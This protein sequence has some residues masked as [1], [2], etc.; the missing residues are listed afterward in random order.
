MNEKQYK[1]LIKKLDTLIAIE[2]AKSG[3]TRKEV[4]E[5]LDTSEKTIER[6]FPFNKLKKSAK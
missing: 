6:M 5:A 2:L 1:E 4:A 3:L